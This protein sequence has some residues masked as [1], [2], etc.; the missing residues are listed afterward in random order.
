MINIVF[1]YKVNEEVFHRD[2]NY[3]KN[4]K[5]ISEETKK[6][7]L[8]VIEEFQNKYNSRDS[9]YVESELIKRFL[10]PDK[11]LKTRIK[12]VTGPISLHRMTHKYYPHI[13]YLFGDEHIKSSGCGNQPAI[14]SYPK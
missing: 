13:F 9:R 6:T 7:L 4:L 3:L 5:G 2:P 10:L 1:F 14:G 12:E 11:F 8:K